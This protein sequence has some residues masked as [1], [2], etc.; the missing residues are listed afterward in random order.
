M[1]CH[2]KVGGQ[3]QEVIVHMTRENFKFDRELQCF[4]L[5]PNFKEKKIRKLVKELCF[6]RDCTPFFKFF[7]DKVRLH[8][9]QTDDD[10]LAVWLSFAHGLPQCPSAMT[11]GI[12]KSCAKIIPGSRMTSLPLE[13]LARYLGLLGRLYWRPGRPTKLLGNARKPAK[14]RSRNFDEILQRCQHQRPSHCLDQSVQSR[15]PSVRENPTLRQHDANDVMPGDQGGDY[16]QADEVLDDLRSL[17]EEEVIYSDRYRAEVIA[18]KQLKNGHLYYLVE[19]E[20]REPTWE[21][22]TSLKQYLDLVEAYE[23][24]S[25]TEIEAVLANLSKKRK[26]HGKTKSN[27]RQKKK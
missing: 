24:K 6:P 11:R 5:R 21:R 16:D 4:V 27:K 8:L 20:T 26:K 14:P 18:G 19:W 22:L 15:F 23:V 1:L 2:F 12:A 10:P 13:T 7:L 17:S 9:I 25:N 3:R